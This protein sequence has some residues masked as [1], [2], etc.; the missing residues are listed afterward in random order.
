MIFKIF[1]FSRQYEH[2]KYSF[3][4]ITWHSLTKIRQW[5]V[6]ATK[7]GF[8]WSNAGSIFDGQDNWIE[9]HIIPDISKPTH[10]TPM[11]SLD[12][13]AKKPTASEV[14]ETKHNGGA[15]GR[16]EKG[17]HALGSKMKP[18]TTNR[19]FFV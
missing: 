14:T 17:F 6:F 15:H 2:T 1:S 3:F 12:I 5:C 10:P 16:G 7:T 18:A 4:N 13:I 9:K 11:L 8:F 19:S